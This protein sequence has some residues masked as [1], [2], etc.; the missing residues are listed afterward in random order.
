MNAYDDL[1][2]GYRPCAGAAVFNAKGDVFVGCRVELKPEEDYAWQM[3]Q[4]GLDK[5]EDPEAAARRELF[6]ETGILSVSLLGAYDDW[7]VYDFPPEILGKRFKKYKGQAQRWFA[8]GFTGSPDE[9][10]LE[11]H[12]EP[13]FQQ[14]DWVPLNRVPSLIVPFKRNVYLSIV[15]A[16]Q[17]LAERWARQGI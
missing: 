15:S 12:G 5:G 4:G 9:I 8:Y 10:N 17:P 13:E 11:H 1:P 16:F 14:W 7:L 3:P 2:Y 6:E